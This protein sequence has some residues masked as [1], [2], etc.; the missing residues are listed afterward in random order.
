MKRG[1]LYSCARREG[2]GVLALGQ[3]LDDLAESFLMSVFHNGLLRTMKAA[4]TVQYVPFPHSRFSIPS[5]PRSTG[6]EI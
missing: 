4:Y 1:R 3:H 6:R 2:Y 5:Y